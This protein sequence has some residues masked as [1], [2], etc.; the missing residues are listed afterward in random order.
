MGRKIYSENAAWVFEVIDRSDAVA[1]IVS[2]DQ[3]H[4]K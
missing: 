2:S 1:L 4:G 3:G